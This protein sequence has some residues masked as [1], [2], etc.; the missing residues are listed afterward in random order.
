M[1]VRSLLLISLALTSLTGQMLA[2]EGAEST[3]YVPFPGFQ[4]SPDMRVFV[5]E[6]EVFV[7]KEDCFG[8]R[9]F[10]T[11]QFA[12]SGE[13]VIKIQSSE[14]I[15]EYEIRPRH[16]AIES[17]QE[18]NSIEF[19]VDGPQM[20][21]VTIND[22][23]PLCLFHTPEETAKPNPNDPNVV[24]FKK[25]VHEVGLITPKSGQTIY[26][27]QG[28]LV[29]G[30]IYAEGVKNV[31]VKGR[32]ILD[33]RGFTSKKEQIGAIKFKNCSNILMDGF[34]LRAGIWWQNLFLL[35][36][37]VEVRNMNLMSFGINNDGFGIDGVERFTV[38]NCF[39]G[40]GDDG[41]GWHAV[42]AEENGQPPTRDC[43]AQN[44]VIYNAQAGNGL[45]VGASLETELFENITFRDITVLSHVNAGIRSD[46]SDW[47][48]VKNLRFE[49]FY[50]EKG[51]RPIEIR[52]EKTRYSN[53][54]GYRDE[55]GE[56]DGLTLK[57]VFA[58]GGE[59]VLEGYS[60]EHA[61]ENVVF[62]NVVVGGKKISSEDQIIKNEFVRNIEFR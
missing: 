4:K 55:R 39:I 17:E 60:E 11:A 51:S 2:K 10:N 8:D 16:L 19:R 62:D 18:N 1:K 29:K 14:P 9:T 37:D 50:I 21:F 49:N 36:Q 31:S 52:I 30:R 13:T 57:N 28:A 54:T 26:L 33:A 3:K 45:R 38:K 56:I 47:A 32:G 53:S 46:H 40:C 44:C 15:K 22:F 27:E 6:Q 43:T 20:L 5:N 41:F 35:C 61:I 25:G 48:T 12:S 24:Y 23:K 42:S 7:A 34:G 59:V 58:P